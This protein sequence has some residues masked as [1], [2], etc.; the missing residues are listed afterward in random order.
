MK[1]IL[2][3]AQLMK[4]YGVKKD[5]ISSKELDKFFL[6]KRK[7]FHLVD[8]AESYENVYSRIRN[9]N[10][11]KYGIITKTKID[12]NICDKILKSIKSLKIK[13]FNTILAHDENQLIGN[14][15]KKNYKRLKS[16]KKK[17]FTKKIG[18]SIYS[19]K[20]CLKIINRFNF[21]VLQ[22]PINL[23]DK[24]FLDKNFLNLVKQKNIKLIY[25]SVFLQGLLTDQRLHKKIFEKK[26]NYIFKK[27]FDWLK[28]NKLKPVE[29]C[30][31]FIKQNKIKNI[32]IGFYKLNEYKEVIKFIN[33]RNKILIPNFIK[34]QND[35]NKILRPD[36][37]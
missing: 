11:K 14:D 5:N 20:N 9:Y 30:I 4:N 10:L 29:A 17:N 32:V 36:L 1:I 35:N 34:D 6:K 16:L 31:Y 3:T 2:G 15:A 23:F 21:D 12:S 28:K 7:F 22:I 26:Q 37:W 25:R 18:V 13:S 33:K 27:Y 24:R 8:T 19:I